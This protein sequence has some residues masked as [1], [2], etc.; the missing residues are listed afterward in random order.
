MLLLSRFL[1]CK[2]LLEVQLNVWRGVEGNKQPCIGM[3]AQI[4]QY[5]PGLYLGRGSWGAGATCVC[6]G[7][8]VCVFRWVCVCVCVLLVYKREETGL[9]FV[10]RVC[11]CVWQCE[12]QKV[13]SE[14]VCVR[15]CVC[16]CVEGSDDAVRSEGALSAER[17]GVQQHQV[18]VVRLFL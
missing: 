4:D 7:V 18:S 14:G 15:V 13:L 17:G 5:Q 10:G 8:C 16:V 3:K 1:R 12:L 11:E 6:V 9:L 2:N